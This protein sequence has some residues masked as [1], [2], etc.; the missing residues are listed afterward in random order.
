MLHEG[1][2]GIGSICVQAPADHLKGPS[3]AAGHW[4]RPPAPVILRLNTV[5]S[6]KSN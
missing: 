2:A 4:R 5:P 3:P 1:A 6:E